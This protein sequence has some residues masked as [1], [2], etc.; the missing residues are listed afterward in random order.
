MTLCPIALAVG[1]Q[2]CPAFKV[3]PLK[4]VIGDQK[5][6]SAPPAAA[7]KTKKR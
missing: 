2:K 3:C 7:K 1:C 6:P 5:Q 4:S